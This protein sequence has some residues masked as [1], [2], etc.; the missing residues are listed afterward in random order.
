[1]KKQF[2]VPRAW[3]I[4][5]VQLFLLCI[6]LLHT[7]EAQN[8]TFA[9]GLNSQPLGGNII[10][11]GIAADGAGNGYSYV[12][13][14]FANTADF[15]PVAGTQNLT[16]AGSN[17]IFLAQYDASG[18]LRW[19]KNIGGTGDD[20]GYAVAVDAS[21]DCYITGYFSG[22]VDF[23]PDA[24][25]QNLTSAGGTDIF[26]AKYDASG[27]YVWAKNMGGTGANIGYAL[28]VDASGNSYLTG[29]FTGTVDFD[30]GAGTQ[31]LTSSASSADI[32]LA[33]YDASGNYIWANDMGGTGVDISYALAVDASGNSYI[34][35]Q[36]N[37]TADFDPGAGTQNLISAS[38]NDIFLAQYDASGNYVWAKKIGSTGND[39]GYAL[40][41]DAS[42]N[43]Y[44]TGQFAGIVDFDPGAG[45]QNRSSSGSNDIFVAKYDASGNYGWARKIGGTGSDIGYALAVDA[46]GNSYI[47]GQFNGTADF[48]PGA[49]TQNLTS[50]GG[51]DIFMAQYDASGNYV[52]AKR[53]GSTGSD[54]GYALSVDAYWG[55]IFSTGNFANGVDFN[56]DAAGSGSILFAG[57]SALNAYVLEF[58]S[59]GN[60]LTV[61]GLGGYS[62]TV[63]NNQ[64]KSIKVDASGNSYVTGYF[65]GTV[66]FDPGAGTQNLASAGSADI[67][68]AKY[69]A[70]G[71]YVWAKSMGGISDDRGTALAIDASGN[72]YIT[73]YFTG[74][75]DFDP[76]AGTQNLTSAGGNDIFLAKYDASGNFIWTKS[77]GGTGG[78]IGYALAIDASG[79][80]YIS[81]YFTGTVD[82]D[83]GAGT[84]N[85]TSSA[86][87]PDIFL[88]KYDASG[89]YVWAKNMGGTSTDIGYALAIDASGNSYISGYF[90]GTA[91]FDPG[92][93]TQN[94][95]SAGSS[96]IFLAKYDAAGN[97]VWAQGM[98]GTGTDIG[99]ALAI[100]ASGN[101]TITGD[102]SNTADFDPGAGTQNLTSAGGVD[103]FLAKY[104]A[105]GSYIWAKGMGGTSN[106]ISYA[107]AVDASG[108]SYITGYF[109][110]T[111][112]FDP[113][114][115]T[116]NLT[117]TGSTD[118]FLAK[119]D[120]SGNYISAKNMG[121]TGGDIG[122][123]LA[124]NASGN[125]FI[126][127]YFSSTADFDPTAGTQNLISL[128][129]SD[130]FIA[131][132]GAI[133]LAIRLESF[134]GQLI[135]HGAAVLLQWTTAI[136]EDNAYFEV[137]RSSGGSDH[138]ALGRVAGCGTCNSRQ[139]YSFKDLQPLTGKNYYRLKIVDKDGKAEYSKWISI[140]KNDGGRSLV[141]YPTMTAGPVEAFYDN[142][143]ATRPIRVSIY[144]TA[145]KAVQQ[146]QGVLVNGSNQ[147][148]VDLSAQAAGLYYIQI[149]E[150]NGQ[151]LATGTAIRQ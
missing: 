11:R 104:D 42:G 49:G 136:Q 44:I 48:D 77:M 91:D 51:N 131:Q 80:S 64:G 54:V 66:D 81:G 126:T 86:T 39:I 18:D 137:E 52:W 129:G 45:T 30:P 139:Q 2:S 12:I 108:N 73:G 124:V 111:A 33:K 103:I 50:A 93:G 75:V 109:D 24:G 20:I 16:S 117:T 88:A 95:T 58:N 22:T 55:T 8:L 115:G 35:G 113:D 150:K 107:L 87:S 3:H 121:G 145:G 118:I 119:Y 144:N 123:G 114:A 141:M 63:F 97:Y 82:F 67:F 110:G 14:Y 60:Y 25:T 26:L 127:G 98:G 15:D 23:D 40:A 34:T 1:M 116:Q 142:A 143:G 10:G 29:Q 76:E 7:V 100:D 56:P 6:S 57:A 47:T 59:T 133:I 78:D 62:T 71:N 151:I 36:F 4:A 101:S 32:F 27:N 148:H 138:T 135:D 134:T 130:L 92:A 38:S 9:K 149:T 70:S 106:D 69:D 90:N 68:L 28:V 41:L 105:S 84:Q 128:N 122:Y 125:S 74:T 102:F 19:A 17:D 61:V 65:S 140:H 46:S 99:Y 21:G 37:G 112:D 72:L 147:L 94:L 83:P 85:L 96:D 89:N 53:I 5:C 132:Y 31:N 43:S 79:N 120:A 146:R 13:G